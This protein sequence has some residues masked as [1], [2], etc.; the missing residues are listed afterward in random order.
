MADLPPSQSSIDVLNT[1]TPNLADLPQRTFT[2]ERPF[3]HEGNCL[4]YYLNPY[5]NVVI[6][7]N[8]RS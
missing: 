6:I 5:V 2:Y 4:I 7:L 8:Q 3:T 1:A